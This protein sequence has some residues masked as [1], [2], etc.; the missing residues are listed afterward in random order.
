MPHS[1]CSSSLV[2]SMQVSLSTAP[3]KHSI[4]LDNPD[5]IGPLQYQSFE[6]RHVTNLL[7]DMRE[8]FVIDPLI[9]KRQQLLLATQLCRMVLKVR[10]LH[11]YYQLS[12]IPSFHDIS[13]ML[14]SQPHRPDGRNALHNTTL[15]AHQL[16]ML[17]NI[18]FNSTFRA[19]RLRY[20]FFEFQGH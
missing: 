2:Q 8:H 17:C 11:L 3:L 15:F 7:I 19:F 18:W 20:F 9:S 6:T 12:H 16:L 13:L 1:D 5:L 14:C 10:F 4:N